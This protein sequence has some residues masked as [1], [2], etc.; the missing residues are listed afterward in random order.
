[1]NHEDAKDTKAQ[2]DIETIAK[3]IVDA[4]VA[5]HKALGPGLLESAYQKC[6]KYELEKRGHSVTVEI[7]MPVTYKDV[8]I[9]AGYRIDMII[10]AMI[11]V[12]NKTVETLMPI[13]QA[14]ILTYLRLGKYKLGFL[15]N[16]N[17]A[18]IKNGIKRVNL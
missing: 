13:H 3:D 8:T 16:W 7:P 1:M 18:L 5:V 15:V 17:V 12:E 6:L 10:D 2:I 9:D 4:I 11:L 14:Q